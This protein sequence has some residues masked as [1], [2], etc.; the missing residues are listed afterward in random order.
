MMRV[1]FEGY[2]EINGRMIYT[3]VT[4]AANDF[5]K[6]PFLLCIP[7]GP[8]FSSIAPEQGVTELEKMS[9]KE[10]STL[11]NVITFD[12]LGCGKSE[13]A[14]NKAEYNMHVFT[15]TAARV[16]EMVKQKMIPNQTM[17]LRVYGG[18]F[19]SMIA[20]DLPL[21]R[22]EWLE[23]GS[24]IRLRQIL[25]FV[26][27]NGAGTKES[28]IKYVAEH[29]KN[30]PKFEIIGD[31]LAK[32]FKGKIKNQNDYIENIVFNLAPLYSDENEKLLNS[33]FGKCL[34]LFYRPMIPLMQ[35]GNFV[36]KKLGYKNNLLNFLLM[37]LTDCSVD[38][39]NQ[40][41]ADNFSGYDVVENVRRHL[42]IYYKVF[43]T[44]VSAHKDHM[45]RPDVAKQVN[46]LLPD[47]SA[48]IIL[49]NKHLINKT[50]TKDIY[51]SIYHNNL[52]GRMPECAVQGPLIVF[53]HVTARFLE[54]FKSLSKPLNLAKVSSSVKHVFDVVGVPSPSPAIALEAD[55]VSVPEQAD[56]KVVQIV[57]N[58]V[59]E[60][61]RVYPGH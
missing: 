31:S 17:D 28:A 52:F 56:N 26:G 14:Q 43:I 15:E 38:V 58:N 5:S 30:H 20:M 37:G 4:S 42:S 53:S 33:A 16:V 61:L 59:T 32:L 18:S 21:H 45:A 29:Y 12:P 36:M 22:P 24:G 23:E 11:P 9:A 27:I 3:K 34:Q 25:S 35:A 7:G 1:I 55:A 49:D 10:R 51:E 19:G 40:F 6:E 2:L 47:T 44:L 8:G 46:A 50:P 60:Q 57:D 39:L 13:K 48:V 41:F 54:H